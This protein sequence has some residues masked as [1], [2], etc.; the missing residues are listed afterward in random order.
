MA[1]PFSDMLGFMSAAGVF[2]YLALFLALI[3]LYYLFL[4]LIGKHMKSAFLKKGVRPKV[5]SVI[6]SMLVTALL[7]VAFFS[8]A[9]GAAMVVIAAIFVIAVVFIL[10]V[11]IGKLAGID[12]PELL[13]MKDKE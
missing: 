13:G 10:F 2:N 1:G 3:V 7:Y 12:V 9:G 6:L 8:V 11:A 4:Y 5:L